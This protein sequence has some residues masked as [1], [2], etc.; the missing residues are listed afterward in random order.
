MVRNR[1]APAVRQLVAAAAAALLLAGCGSYL[2]EEALLEA[3]K[4]LLAANNALFRA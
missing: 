1:R 4:A 3:N 2:S